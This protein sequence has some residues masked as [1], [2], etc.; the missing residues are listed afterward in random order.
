ME[1]SIVI[2][3]TIVMLV[4]LGIVLRLSTKRLKQIAENEKLNEMTASFP[5]NID[6]GKSILEKL[7]N[8]EVKIEENRDSKSSLYLVFS[9]K[10]S[11][12]N[13]RDNFTR[14]QTIAHECVHSTQSKRMLWGNF[15]YSNLYLIYFWMI[16]ALTI[17]R[18]IDPSMLQVVVLL[19]FGA[20][21][22]VIRGMLETDAMIKARYVAKEY[23]E[24][25]NIASKAQIDEIIGE[26]DK[27]NEVGIKLVN[28]TL[29]TKNCFKVIVYCIICLFVV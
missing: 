8:K 19:L 7:N 18:V 12:A 28:Y 11:I 15:I 16:V 20:I 27:L 2:G 5:E 10:I 26:Y 29:F 23:L 21:H 24:E 3:I 13:I 22:Y 6:I 17:F 9:N 14:I 1:Y 25:N 4:V